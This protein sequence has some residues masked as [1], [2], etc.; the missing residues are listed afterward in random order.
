MNR[1]ARNPGELLGKVLKLCQSDS[2][3]QKKADRVTEV[4]QQLDRQ[5][6]SPIMEIAESPEHVTPPFLL[7]ISCS[8][9]IILA[10]VA[11]NE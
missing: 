7:D 2:F 9:V 8:A 5:G 10:L 11:D 4:L 6:I 1:I 3:E